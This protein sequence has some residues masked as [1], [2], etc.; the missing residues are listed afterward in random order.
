MTKNRGQA[1]ERQE[2][3]KK[4]M[5]ERGRCRVKAWVGVGRATESPETPNLE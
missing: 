3:E 2:P 5:V 1:S 4:V